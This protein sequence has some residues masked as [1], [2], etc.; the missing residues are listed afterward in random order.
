[1]RHPSPVRVA[2]MEAIRIRQE[3]VRR[4]E[5]ELAARAPDNLA[6]F[7]R[8]MWPEVEPRVPLVWSRH[9]AVI[10]REA[11]EH[12]ASPI[13][14]PRDLVINIPPRHSKSTL[15]GVMLPAWVWLTRPETQIVA[16]TKSEKNAL[17]DARLMRRVVRSPRYRELVEHLHATRGLP[18]WELS[19]DQDRVAYYATT[20][21]GHR[22][23][24]T[25]TSAVTG[26]GA[27]ILILDDVYDAQ[28]VVTTSGERQAQI[29]EEVRD[30]YEEVWVPRLNPPRPRVYV[31]MQRLHQ[32]DIAGYLLG[33]GAR[34]VRSVVLPMLAESDHPHRYAREWRQEGE[35]LAPERFPAHMIEALNDGGLRWVGQYQQRPV[36][37]DGGLFRAEWL[38]RRYDCPPRE[39]PAEYRV[40]S[41]DAAYKGTATADYCAVTVWGVAGTT[42]ALLHAYRGRHDYPGLRAVVRRLRAEWP[43]ELT[44]IEDRAN[45]PALIA[46][47]RAEVPGLVAWVP[48][49]AKEARAHVAAGYMEAGTVTFPQPEYAPWWH[50][51]AAEMLAFPRGRH[52]DQVDSTTQAL[53]YLG[54]L[55]NGGAGVY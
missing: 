40:M 53:V 22:I 10:C 15:I 37:R 44:I 46:E 26:A 29:M 13:D 49:A 16:V 48:T 4:R 41:I 17:R 32:A 12:H 43:C 8:L 24:I 36:P 52:D 7:V 51:Y 34:S 20:V 27:D 11:A 33:R 45:G 55:A 3:L 2:L 5:R 28:E 21:G 54:G 31:V 35:V 1:M 19:D 9:M 38:D 42:R 47:L 30:R 25:T 18:M 14:A 39:W 23:S 6:A 50:D